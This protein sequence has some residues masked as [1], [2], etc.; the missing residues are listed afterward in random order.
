MSRRKRFKKKQS[1][2]AIDS[3]T[4]FENKNDL[5]NV[6]NKYTENN[7]NNQGNIKSWFLTT[8][9]SIVY[10]IKNMCCVKSPNNAST[11][12]NTISQTFVCSN[13]LIFSKTNNF[14]CIK[15]M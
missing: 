14:F 10:C 15:I 9:N 2:E 1:F 8:K 6:T 11:T 5:S 7:D 3:L 4:Q 13:M 12:I